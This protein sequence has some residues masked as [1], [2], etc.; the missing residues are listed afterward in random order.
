[1]RIM[2]Y[3][4][5]SQVGGAEVHVLTLAQ[6]LVER[7]HQVK[8][9]CPRGRPLTAELAS[10]GIPLIT[11]RTTG[12]LDP[13]TLL[14][15]ARWL[16]RGHYDVM[17][18]HL[19]TASLL[20]NL[21]GRLAG[22]P[23]VSTVHGFN[24]ATAFRGCR[25][26][27]AVSQAVRD[28]LLEQGIPEERVRVVLN[29]IAI[30]QPPQAETVEELRR[31]LQ[32]P[33]GTLVLGTVA[34]LRPEKGHRYLL[35]A[36]AE[37]GT[38]SSLP[39]LRVLFVG[40]GTEREALASLAAQLGLADRVHFA[41]F[42]REVPP[43]LAATD[44]FVLPSL[45]EGLSLATL[46]AMA[47]ARPVVA[48]RVGGTPEVVEHGR[49]GL[50]VEPS[51]AKELAGAIGKL[52]RSPQMARAMGQAGRQRVLEQFGL[53]RMVSGIE[54]IYQAAVRAGQKRSR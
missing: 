16:R 15:V 2:Q 37:L 50:L 28:H 45:K 43:Y 42:Q 14:R 19:S 33:P 26:L 38:D 29:G 40:D 54:S 21:A 7:G 36:V 13:V 48:S 6:R 52:A 3:I 23:V 46:E 44:I 27:I 34:R 32:A 12:K 51:H 30:P 4:T 9:I 47:L 10:R 41:G 1:M 53:D 25:H 22:V 24:T 39:P 35:E 20:G 49:T 8:V 11:P 31:G 5:P 17:H 18:T